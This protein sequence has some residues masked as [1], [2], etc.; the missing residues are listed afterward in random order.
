MLTNRCI[1][2]LSAGRVSVGV[3]VDSAKGKFE[4]VQMLE[5][6]SDKG[7]D[8]RDWVRDWELV[9]FRELKRENSV[10]GLG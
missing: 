10:E 1:Y 2:F 7:R 4:S 9:E 3:Q 8:L 6:R 5:L